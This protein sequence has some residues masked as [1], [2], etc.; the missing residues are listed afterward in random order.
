MKVLST[1]VSAPWRLAAAATA[2][3]SVTV[4]SGLA[5]LSI[6]TALTDGSNAASSAAGSVVSAM[7]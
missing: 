4:S 6:S 2:V 3:M 1:M 5:G 7:S